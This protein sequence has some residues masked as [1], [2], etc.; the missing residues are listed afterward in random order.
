MASI[1]DCLLQKVALNK[2]SARTVDKITKVLDD[3]KAAKDSGTDLVKEIEVAQQAHEL[4]TK[5]FNQK[6]RQI[7][8]HAD[9]VANSLGRFKEGVPDEVVLGS[10]AFADEADRYKY[11][12]LG[13]SALERVDHHERIYTS[14]ATE[15]LDNLN[16]KRLTVLSS[17]E[18]Q[19]ELI[20]D[21]YAA[22][23][24]EGKRSANSEVTK[25][26]DTIKK[27]VEAAEAD[28]ERAG[29]EIGFRKKNI[30]GMNNM[31][32]KLNSV[33][34]DE[35]AKDA[36]KLFDLQ[37]LE[38]MIPGITKDTKKLEAIF[39]EIHT[40]M[41]SGGYSR[42][43]DLVPEG[44]K[45]ILTRRNF[46]RL[47]QLKDADSYIAYHD[48]YASSEMYQNLI[49]FAK[50][51]GKEVG[52]L[53]VYGPKPRALMR[54]LLN[55]V[56][57]G[58]A[59]E[60]K[61]LAERHYMELSGEWDKG[62]NASLAKA[63]N[64]YRSLHSA[65]KLGFS[66]L[67]AAI[68]DAVGLAAV[69]RRLRGLPAL[70]TIVNNLKRVFSSGIE[71]D[72][73]LWAQL[74]WYTDSYIDDS[75]SLLRQAEAE[76]AHRFASFATQ[77]VFKYTGLTRQTN[78]LKGTS[79]RD[80]AH[81]LAEIKYDGANTR[82][83]NWLAAHGISKEDLELFQKFGKEKVEDWDLE[84]LSPAKLYQEG[85]KEE[86]A[87]LGSI[88]GQIA[89]VAS[90]TSSR[91]LKAYFGAIER[92]GKLTQFVVG[93]NKMFT[94]YLGSFYN[95]HLRVLAAQ[96]GPEKFIH[97]G[98]YAIALTMAALV[99]GWA[100]DLV[101]GKEPALTDDAIAKAVARANV[102]PIVGDLILSGGAQTGSGMYQK[103]TGAMLGDVE[104][105]VSSLKNL[106][107]GETGK[108]GV[109][110]TKILEGLIPGKT[111]WFASL[112]FNR[113]IL[114]QL[115]LLYDP[116][117]K[118][119]FDRQTQKAYNSGTPYFW[120]PGKMQPDRAPSLE[121]LKEFKKVKDTN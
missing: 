117:A 30:L 19:T 51:A 97:A 48:K 27:I 120:R 4:I 34:A 26:T 108:A 62:L 5:Q 45:S 3:L 21:M 64:T 25:A 31:V 75:L 95:N 88:L 66:G 42:L 89:E 37:V 33:T 18:G 68:S 23:R 84:V 100:R 91:K 121:G 65:N 47:L 106:V 118:E 49:N 116:E 15:V 24:N 119:K 9:V 111:A 81:T 73:K 36:M 29:G 78:S 82:L 104:K 90:P 107:S 85:Y 110:L 103:L 10:F 113:V 76:G 46:S 8:I 43:S 6:T 74:G 59:P 86:A 32:D 13:P 53:E 79:I 109:D 54:T 83:K 93:S 87:K 71:K 52:I 14:M 57:P 11:G 7:A 70:Q 101:N 50:E 41:I 58:K 67:D 38:D 99:S 94:G 77:K 28:I 115:K 55:N 12:Y 40:S 56:E 63:L 2:V 39:K 105:G 61:K 22:M 60:L 69:S 92:Q 16:P 80:T 114:D 112:V 98:A 35:Y 17:K 72:Y 1:V 102:I 20:K 44:A 96:K